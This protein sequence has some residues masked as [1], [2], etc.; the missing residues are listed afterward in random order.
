MFVGLIKICVS[1]HI[2]SFLECCIIFIIAVKNFYGVQLSTQ[3][4][5]AFTAHH[6]DSSMQPEVVTHTLHFS[7]PKLILLFSNEWRLCQ[8]ARIID[9]YSYSVLVRLHILNL[10]SLLQP[11]CLAQN[12]HI[13]H[14]YY[15]NSTLAAFSASSLSYPKFS[16]FYATRVNFLK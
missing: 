15:F 14:L 12:P 1:K 13:S 2:S 10:Y 11:H 5:T 4:R 6:S 7:L 8:R 16:M 9:L 3:L